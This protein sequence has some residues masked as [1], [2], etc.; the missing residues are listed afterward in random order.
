MRARD[1][2][3]AL[4]GIALLA[5][6][7]GGGGSGGPASVTASPSSEVYQ[8]YLAYS[9]CMRAHGAPFWPD[10]DTTYSDGAYEYPITAQILAAEHGPSWNAAL[11][12]CAKQAPPLLPFTAS[13]LAPARSRLLKV[14]QCMRSH[15]FPSWPDPEINPYGIGYLSRPR[16][17]IP[18]NPKFQAA[19]QACHSGSG[20]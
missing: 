18:S 17:A 3:A 20:P 2:V 14:T 15:G 5:T 8:K 9:R 4:A 19:E 7:C 13:Q 12:A 6:A 11:S 16:G 1:R 10:P